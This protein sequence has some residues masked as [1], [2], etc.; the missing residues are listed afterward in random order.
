MGEGLEENGIERVL[1]LDPRSD[2]WLD[3]DSG[4]GNQSSL[5]TRPNVGSR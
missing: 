1:G 5:D 4:N 2:R 3:P